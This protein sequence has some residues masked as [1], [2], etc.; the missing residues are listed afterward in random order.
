VK[1]A[2]AE[3]AARKDITTRLLVETSRLGDAVIRAKA[4]GIVSGH[5]AAQATF[6]ALDQAIAYSAAASDGTFVERGAA[7]AR[8]YGHVRPILSAERT[9]LNF[10]QHLSGVATLTAAFVERVRGTAAVILDTRKTTPG[11]RILEKEAVLHGGG[12]SHRSGLADMILVKDNHIAAAGGL[13]A[14][15]RKLSASNLA[16]A[17]IEVASLEDL[18]ALRERPP[19]R[20]MLDNFEPEMVREAVV[21]IKGWAKVPEIEVSGGVSLDTVAA[22]AAVGVDFISVGA[23]TNRAPALDM[24][25]ELEG[26]DQK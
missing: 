15:L 6:K 23:L 7:V 2:L 16:G 18:R 13:E 20:I 11:M 4:S 14:A 22:Y 25:L 17:E 10:L 21:E 26:I 12:R 9:A 3:D 8:V 5:R 19:R 1:A 24:S